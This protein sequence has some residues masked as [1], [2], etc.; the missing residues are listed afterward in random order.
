MSTLDLPPNDS[1]VFPKLPK[2]ICQFLTDPVKAFLQQNH[3][4]NYSIN[5]CHAF[6]KIE[7]LAG[8]RSHLFKIL[9]DTYNETFAKEAS[10]LLTVVHVNKFIKTDHT[11][12]SRTPAQIESDRVFSAQ[13]SAAARVRQQR[14]AEEN[15]A[16]LIAKTQRTKDLAE[17]ALAAESTVKA[18]KDWIA[19]LF[20]SDGTPIDRIVLLSD[21]ERK[22]EQLK[23][24]IEAHL[25]KLRGKAADESTTCLDVVVDLEKILPLLRSHEALKTLDLGT[26]DPADDIPTGPVAPPSKRKSGGQKNV[27]RWTSS[28]PFDARKGGLRNFNKCHRSKLNNLD[29]TLKKMKEDLTSRVHLEEEAVDKQKINAQN[30]RIGLKKTPEQAKIESLKPTLMVDLTTEELTGMLNF[31]INVIFSRLP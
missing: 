12:H 3:F 4:I 13:K 18:G 17:L 29:K 22:V 8:L 25:K 19:L 27:F 26:D 6:K 10:K 23:T 31:I 1:I 28:H 11:K 14:T 21:D 7:D 15:A 30:R 24:D 20:Q 2:S 5:T 16:A 9:S